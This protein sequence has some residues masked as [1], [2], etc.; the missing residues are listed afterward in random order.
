MK[1]NWL[2]DEK[3]GQTRFYL[4]QAKKALKTAA[5][6]LISVAKP[7]KRFLPMMLRLNRG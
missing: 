4:N 5:F 6:V 2:D 1:N 3:Q 7:W